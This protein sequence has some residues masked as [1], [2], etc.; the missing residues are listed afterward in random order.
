MSS[1][2]QAALGALLSGALLGVS[3]EE[4]LQVALAPMEAVAVV[5]SA[6]SVWL[7]ARNLAAGWWVGLVG[8]SAYAVVFVEQR[9]FAEVGLQAVYFVTSLQALWIWLRGG[10]R[11]TERPVTRLPRNWRG[12]TLV[13]L[14]LSTAALVALLTWARGAAPLLD[15]LVT[16]LSL[17]AQVYLMLRYVESWHLW[18]LVDVISVP[19]YAWRGLYLSSA[20]YV[21]FGVMAY[22]GLRTFERAA[23]EGGA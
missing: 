11:R 6:W 17:A 15:A 12:P 10:E 8:V 3:A 22:Q 20:L 18:V 23:E 13:A 1:R 16:T 2:L 21:V 14:A 19:L 9:L 5:A 7:L 4:G